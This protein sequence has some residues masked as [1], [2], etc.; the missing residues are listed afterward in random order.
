MSATI[1]A[2]FVVLALVSLITITASVAKGIASGKE[3][4]AELS[5]GQTG[6]QAARMESLPPLRNRRDVSLPKYSRQAV[7]LRPMRPPAVAA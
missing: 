6:R 5:G 1:A 2:L 7:R 3:M 4:V